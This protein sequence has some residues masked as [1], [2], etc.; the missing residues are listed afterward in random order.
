MLTADQA[1]IYI[2]KYVIPQSDKSNEKILRQIIF[3]LA[4]LDWLR[5]AK[6]IVEQNPE[7]MYEQYVRELDL[8]SK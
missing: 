8:V 3:T 1:K 7:L 6:I 2:S 5:V 4:E